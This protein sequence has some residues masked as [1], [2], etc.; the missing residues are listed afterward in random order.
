M[1]LWLYKSLS[2]IKKISDSP[3]AKTEHKAAICIFEIKFEIVAIVA[4]LVVKSTFAKA[5]AMCKAN[6]IKFDQT[7]F[8]SVFEK[9]K[10]KAVEACVAGITSKGEKTGALAASGGT[11][12]LGAGTAIGAAALTTAITNTGTLFGVSYSISSGSVSTLLGSSAVAS[13]VPVAGWIAAGVGILAT[14]GLA[15]FGGG[16]HSES[17]LDVKSLVDGFINQFANEFS[18]WVENKKKY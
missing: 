16:R 5:K 3:T 1:H 6:S 4:S 18:E 14:L 2:N 10:T 7:T 11:A 8:D 9:A 17:Y 13:T 15:I 12:L